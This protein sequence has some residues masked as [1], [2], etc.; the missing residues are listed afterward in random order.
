MRIGKKYLTLVLLIS[1]LSVYAGNPNPTAVRLERYQFDKIVIKGVTNVSNFVLKYSEQGYVNVPHA[2][3]NVVDSITIAIPAEDFEAD[4]KLMLKDFLSLINA[5]KH[6]NIDISIDENFKNELLSFNTG[7]MNRVQINMNGITN[8][9]TCACE[10][11]KCLSG[12]WCLL[13]QLEVKLTD[14]E[15]DPPSKFW[16]LIKVKDEVTIGFRILFIFAPTDVTQ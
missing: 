10:F 2:D 12:Q 15:I 3:S 8:S 5:D 4:S 16:G 14:F 13:G 6:P 9:Y 1:K 7:G 11:S